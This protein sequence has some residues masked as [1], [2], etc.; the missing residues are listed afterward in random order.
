MRI[1]TWLG[2]LLWAAHCCTAAWASSD[3]PAA[4][5]CWL[6][7]SERVGFYN[8]K[9]TVYK[10][11]STSPLL[12]IAYLWSPVK[13][14]IHCPTTRNAVYVA[15]DMPSL[16]SATKNKDTAPCGWESL[17]DRRVCHLQRPA[18]TQ[19]MV[20]VEADQDCQVTS[21]ARLDYLMLVSGLGGLVFFYA[22]PALSSSVVFRLSCGSALFTTGS[23]IVLLIFLFRFIPHKRTVSAVMAAT[24]SGGMAI[25]RWLTGK[26]IPPLSQLLQSRA[27]GA[28]VL[29]S[30][31]GGAAATYLYDDRSNPKVNTLIKCIALQ[32]E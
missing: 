3:A 19:T 7:H 27:F 30:A 12:L 21:E 10:C 17:V 14:D 15:P 11:P 28:Y 4:E 5:W 31:A 9:L 6:D 32:H 26:W 24:G 25:L 16:L 29:V 23:L 20:G 1:V 13:I 22:A 2:C 8:K 18:F